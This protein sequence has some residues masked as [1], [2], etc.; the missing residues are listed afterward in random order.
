M[1]STARISAGSIF[2]LVLYKAIVISIYCQ[3][4]WKH[5]CQSSWKRLEISSLQQNYYRTKRGCTRK[6]HAQRD[7]DEVDREDRNC[8]R[9]ARQF[10]QR[11]QRTIFHLCT[12][13][14]INT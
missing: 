9:L 7:P 3:L 12:L 5:T 8:T 4:S 13:S 10:G 11:V 6:W 14:I 1:E 2:L